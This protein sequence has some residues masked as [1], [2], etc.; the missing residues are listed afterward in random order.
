MRSVHET[1][2]MRPNDA[3]AKV[4]A[5]S[6][7]GTPASKLQR[8]RLKLT[9]PREPG[10]EHEPHHVEAPVI[11][12]P[13]T[14]HELEENSM[15]EFGPELDFDEY[16]LALPPRD[17]YRLLRRQIAWA[18]KETAQLQAEWEVLRP[19][20]EAAWREK[21][22]IFD[23]LIDAEIGLLSAMVGSVPPAHLT[24]SLEKLQRQ[25]QQFQ[26]QQEQL[27]KAAEVP[28]VEGA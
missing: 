15:P 13:L 18:G 4:G 20:R 11:I 26:S 3:I 17:L 22:A 10:T 6:T 7:T 8:I 19:Q 28:H 5:P 14:E 21:E 9:Q 12:P 16:E 1:D 23:D 2:T 25:Q 27:A 24:T